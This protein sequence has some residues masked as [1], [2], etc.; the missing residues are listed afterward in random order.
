MV[1]PK[2]NQTFSG[3]SG[4][5]QNFHVVLS[6]GSLRRFDQSEF[7]FF[8]IALSIFIGKINFRWSKIKKIKSLLIK[9]NNLCI[10]T[11]TIAYDSLQT[12]FVKRVEKRF[13]FVFSS[14]FTILFQWSKLA[15]L[16][17]RIWNWKTIKNIIFKLILF[18][19]RL[20]CFHLILWMGW[21][22]IK[23]RNSIFFSSKTDSNTN[24]KLKCSWGFLYG[25]YA[26]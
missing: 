4:K 9:S 18:C 20:S 25:Y 3:L 22:E 13:F 2:S 1:R 21:M 6:W 14:D 11:R 10:S 16:N 5:E 19:Y 12:H 7:C 24:N 8:S 17:D 23:L 15:C 26:A